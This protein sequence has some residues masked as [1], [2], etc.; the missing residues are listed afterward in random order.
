MSFGSVLRNE[1]EE[2]K[3]VEVVMYADTKSLCFQP[4]PEL[5]RCPE[6]CTDYYF[7]LLGELL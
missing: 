7:E 4:H 1:E 6:E 5:E 2:H 3:D